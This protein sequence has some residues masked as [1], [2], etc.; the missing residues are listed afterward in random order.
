MI[1]VGVNQG[2][3]ISPYLFLLVMNEFMKG[4]QDKAPQC[5][6][7]AG[8]MVLVDE[9]MNMIEGKLNVGENCKRKMD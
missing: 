7:F 3:T 1:K 2:L 8:Y 6:M 5:M 9:D 4:V